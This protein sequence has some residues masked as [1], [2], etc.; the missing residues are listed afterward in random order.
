VAEGFAVYRPTLDQYAKL[1]RRQADA[2]A[3]VHHRLTAIDV[4][5]G[6]SAS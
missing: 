2:V 6:R 3:D 1:I 4:L 5:P